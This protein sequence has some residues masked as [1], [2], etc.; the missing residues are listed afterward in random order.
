MQ[1][2]TISKIIS[3]KMEQ[4][5]ETITDKKLRNKVRKNILVSGGCI[6]SMFFNEDVNDFDVYINDMDIL[7]KLVQYY[8]KPFNIM[9]LDGRKDRNTNNDNE[10]H[11][12]IA[13]RTLKED[14]IKLYFETG[15]GMRV[16]EDKKEEELNYSPIFFSPNAISLSNKVQIVCRFHGDNI[17]IHK[18]FDFIHATNYFTFQE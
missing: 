4:W 5:L 12:S 17:A 14:Q 8:A 2:K 16:N 15:S 18:T 9:I 7:K 10:N 11:Y 13:T 3:M 1:T 6:T